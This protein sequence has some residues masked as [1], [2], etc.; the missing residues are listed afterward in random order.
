MCQAEFGDTAKIT[1]ATV[2]IVVCH[3]SKQAILAAAVVAGIIS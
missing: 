1:E 2:L 3:V